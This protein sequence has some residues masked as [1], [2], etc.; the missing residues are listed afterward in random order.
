MG[1]K[2]TDAQWRLVCDLVEFI[3]RRPGADALFEHCIERGLSAEQTIRE[4]SKVPAVDLT[5]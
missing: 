2:L 4:L 5:S 3:E 1:H